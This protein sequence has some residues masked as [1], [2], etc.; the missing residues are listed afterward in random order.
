MFLRAQIPTPAYSADSPASQAGRRPRLFW[1]RELPCTCS[2]TVE[3]ANVAFF[4]GCKRILKT[5]AYKR[6]LLSVNRF[7]CRW[8][9]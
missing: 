3:K 5:S 2:L 1:G 6:S 8:L 7:I 9:L 4:T